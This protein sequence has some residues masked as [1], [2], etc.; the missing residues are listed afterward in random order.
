MKT[1]WNGVLRPTR[2]ASECRRSLSA[3]LCSYGQFHGVSL[4][5]C[6]A[7]SLCASNAVS[8]VPRGPVV[9]ENRPTLFVSMSKSSTTLSGIKA[10]SSARQHEEDKRAERKRACLVL[11]MA[12]LAN[13][14]YRTAAEKAAQV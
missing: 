8:A 4:A 12:H 10:A 2:R 5:P 7:S 6:T 13:E 1:A 3:M 9:G 14:G 11:A